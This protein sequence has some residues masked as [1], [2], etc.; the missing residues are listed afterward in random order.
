MEKKMTWKEIEKKYPDEW[1][2][3][4]DYDFT[5]FGEVKDGIVV[6]HS[7]NKE[8]IYSYPIEADKVGIW[9]TGESPF[10]GLRSHVE[11]YAV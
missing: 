9:Y 10:R 11:D 6:T 4:V 1:V 7:T 2:L 5:E 3:V 8:E